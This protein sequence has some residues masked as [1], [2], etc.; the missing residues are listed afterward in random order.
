MSKG[1]HNLFPEPVWHLLS[2]NSKLCW[3]LPFRHVKRSEKKVPNR[4]EARKVFIESGLL[5]GVVKTMKRGRRNEIAHSA[6]DERSAETPAER[7]NATT[8]KIVN[9]RA[10]GLKRR[11]WAIQYARSVSRPRRQLGR[12][13]TAE[14]RRSSAVNKDTPKPCF[15][16]PRRSWPKTLPTSSPT[17]TNQGA[18]PTTFPPKR[19]NLKKP[20]DL[21]LFCTVRTISK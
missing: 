18:P 2:N 4:E 8:A 15:G 5:R 17:P 19:K 13:A 1:P 16:A 7:A 12:F 10:R 3:N 14:N 6:M 9:A 11:G 21:E 20:D